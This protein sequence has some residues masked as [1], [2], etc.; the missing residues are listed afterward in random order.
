MTTLHIT[1]LIIALGIIAGLSYWA[2]NL[3]QQVKKKEKDIL[4]S[5]NQ[6][7]DNIIESIRVIA[8]AYE[9]QQVE[10]IE[11]SIRLKVLLDNLPL[12]AE[13][14]QP[15]IVLDVI[16]EKVGHIP[17]HEN[18]KALSRKEKFQYEK[19]MASIEQEYKDLFTATAK[20]LKT[21][22]FDIKPKV[23]YN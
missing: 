3:T 22:A 9:D 6:R 1:L 5:V 18:W 8:S 2:W 13:E 16:Y 15:F 19:E 7:H 17:T 11:A 10:L 4:D 14:K 21:Y 23:T 12:S 20:E